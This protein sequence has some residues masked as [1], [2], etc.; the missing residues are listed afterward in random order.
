MGV[1]DGI[2]VVEVA[3]GSSLRGCDPRRLGADVVKVERDR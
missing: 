2:K 1:M 3:R